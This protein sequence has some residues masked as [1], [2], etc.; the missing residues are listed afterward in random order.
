MSILLIHKDEHVHISVHMAWLE[1]SG[2]RWTIYVRPL[3]LRCLQ[4]R[5]RGDIDTI[6]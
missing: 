6:C 5:E 2:Y 3:L 4:E 1:T